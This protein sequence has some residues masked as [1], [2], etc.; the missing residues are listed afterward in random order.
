MMYAGLA[1]PNLHI[2]HHVEERCQ[3]HAPGRTGAKP[4]LHLPTAT[5]SGPVQGRF[6]DWSGMRF[7]K[8]A[9]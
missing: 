8:T 4:V 5:D 9:A 1:K 3:V 2:A 7:S 6:G